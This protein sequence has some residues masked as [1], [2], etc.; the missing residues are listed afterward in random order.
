[1]PRAAAHGHLHVVAFVLVVVDVE[2]DEFQRIRSANKS[3]TYDYCP[4]QGR[5]RSCGPP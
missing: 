1:M 2:V 5:G 4:N 3:A